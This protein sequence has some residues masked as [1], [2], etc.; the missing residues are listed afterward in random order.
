MRNHRG[1]STARLFPHMWWAA[2]AMLCGLAFTPPAP[3]AARTTPED[4]ALFIQSAHSASLLDAGREAILQ[5]RLSR[6][7]QT[8]LQLADQPDG[9]VAAAFYL[10][11][12]A[13]L[14]F[15]MSDEDRYHDAFFARSDTLKQRLAPLPD[16]PWRA[17]VQA[18]AA[19]H[20]A[21]VRAKRGQYVRAL[22]AGKAAYEGY[23]RLVDRYPDFYDAYK[24]LGLFHLSIGSVTGRYRLLLRVLGLKGTVEDG[25]RELTLAAERSRYSREEA[26][27]YLAM[28]DLKLFESAGDGG[29]RLAS[30][31]HTYEDSPLW[32][33]LYG[34][35]LYQNRR[36]AEAERALRTAVD[37][38]G[39]GAHFYIDYA[40]YY[41]ADVLFRQNRFEEATFY[42]Q[43][44]LDQHDGPSLKALAALGL[45]L[46][47]EMHGERD[48]AVPCYARVKATRDFDS[49]LAAERLA[50][51]LLQ[52]PMTDRERV[53]LL[54]QNAF[55]AGR[56]DEVH[57]RLRPL[58]DD[59][60]ATQDERAEAAYRRGRA[61][62]A[63]NRT[64][65][66]LASYATA[67][68]LHG[69]PDARWA[70]WSQY[71]RGLILDASGDPGAAADAFRAA[72]AYKP[73]YAYHQ[74]L[75]RSA[76]AALHRTDL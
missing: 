19:M 8:F 27:V 45:G 46:A 1:Y 6:A 3:P 12:I 21:L 29:E 11:T 73:T 26:Q 14:Q 68:Q 5:F 63:Q 66:A 9:R 40:D 62:H 23:N 35:Y 15:M 61:F 37:A 39:D 28:I 17:F 32:A 24:G 7:E 71:Y 33:Y 64:D 44:Y 48:R 76:K 42:Y 16:S 54:A 72:L 47:L 55:D 52:A 25:I 41:M 13:L 59:P 57:E 22:F 34:E 18:E 4:G 51:R 10:E 53:L 60:E 31:A 69:D 56:Y 49:D 36:A 38:Y 58:E 67:V 75:E 50:Q 70:P 30:L 74:A 2:L 43:R 20:R 65:E